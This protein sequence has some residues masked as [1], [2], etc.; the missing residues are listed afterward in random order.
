MEELPKKE[1]CELVPLL[2]KNTYEKEQMMK[3]HKRTRTENIILIIC[4][5]VIIITI[6]FVLY[7][8]RYSM[9]LEKY[10]DYEPITLN[11]TQE[12]KLL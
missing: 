9:F 10:K 8:M 6:C 4:A 1:F 7:V 5:L 3:K 11:L 2:F 12:E